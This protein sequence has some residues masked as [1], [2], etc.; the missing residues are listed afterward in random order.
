MRAEAGTTQ[1]SPPYFPHL[2]GGPQAQRSALPF[3]GGHGEYGERLTTRKQSPI[4]AHERPS[5]HY[6]CCSSGTSQRAIARRQEGVI[7]DSAKRPSCTADR[8]YYGSVNQ[9]SGRGAGSRPRAHRQTGTLGSLAECPAIRF[10]RDR[11]A[12]AGRG[13]RPEKFFLRQPLR[14]NFGNCAVLWR[15]QHR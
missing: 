11:A 15:A 14:S 7:N 4:R 5:P 6:V 12:S 10:A 2:L 1:R 9:P 3:C 13:P 8:Q